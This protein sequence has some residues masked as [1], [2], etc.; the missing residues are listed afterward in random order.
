MDPITFDA[1]HLQ[2]V[3]AMHLTS[4]MNLTFIG[5]EKLASNP[6]FPRPPSPARASPDV[7]GHRKSVELDSEGLEKQLDEDMERSLAEDVATDDHNA[8]KKFGAATQ[9]EGCDAAV[10]QSGSHS[11]IAGT[12][13]KSASNTALSVTVREEQDHDSSADSST[14]PPLGM[15]MFLM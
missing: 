8:D 4:L 13:V 12:S 3:T 2:G 1:S 5:D 6:L 15:Y 11:G 7:D 10:T 9:T 14:N